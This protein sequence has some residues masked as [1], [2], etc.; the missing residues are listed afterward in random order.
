MSPSP[1]H[2]RTPSHRPP[3]EA[4]ASPPHMRCEASPLAPQEALR[5]IDVA[6]LLTLVQSFAAILKRPDTVIFV[7]FRFTRRQLPILLGKGFLRTMKRE[8]DED[9]MRLSRKAKD[10][11][12][13][14]GAEAEGHV[15]QAEG[16]VAQAEGRVTR[17]GAAEDSPQPPPPPPPAAAASRAPVRLEPLADKGQPKVG[18]SRVAPQPIPEPATDS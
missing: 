16:H 3:L 4:L 1:S 2:L 5:I 17:V 7:H 15:A 6:L 12:R 10:P 8:R 18:K 11:Q 13:G 14:G 9:S